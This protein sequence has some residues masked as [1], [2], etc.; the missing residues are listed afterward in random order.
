MIFHLKPPSPDPKQT[1]T[2]VWA[3]MCPINKI[4]P[5]LQVGPRTQE[6]A[7][8]VLH[9]FALR[10]MP[11]SAPLFLTECVASPCGMA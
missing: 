8:S 7:H 1:I 10:L 4:I 3:A 11:D 9:E 6:L 2:W 5:V